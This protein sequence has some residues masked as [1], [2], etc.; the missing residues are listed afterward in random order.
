[1]REAYKAL[2]TAFPEFEDISSIYLA[3][4]TMARLLGL[5][6]KY[7]NCCINMCC[8]YTRKYEGLDQCPFPNCNEPRR[9]KCGK[10]RKKFQYLL[11]IPHLIAL[12]FNKATV[13]KM[14]YRHTYREARKT[15][16]VTN[17]F[18]G[19]LYWELCEEEVTT[20]GKEYSHRYFSDH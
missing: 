11:I 14:A 12:F 15:E 7:V 13:E 17:V 9:D 2:R 8:C 16:D 10:S 1:M 19:A 4:K 20:N 5:D 18:D 3:Q 6:P